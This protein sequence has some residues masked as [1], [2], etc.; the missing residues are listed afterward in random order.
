MAREKN[1]RRLVKFWWL[2]AFTAGVAV[3]AI[4][5]SV[6]G[7]QRTAWIASFLGAMACA[8][9][10]YEQFS[11]PAAVTRFTSRPRGGWTRRGWLHPTSPRKP[12]KVK[13]APR[14]G[15]LRAIDGRKQTPSANSPETRPPSSDAPPTSGAS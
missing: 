13:P 2:A 3:G 10:I 4:S 7:A 15:Q 8:V 1:S 12:V 14:R 6:A 11:D 5:L 9:A